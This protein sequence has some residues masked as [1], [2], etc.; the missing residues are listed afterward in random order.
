[1]LVL[2]MV[3]AVLAVARLAALIADDE[4]TVSLRRRVVERFG[5]NS[6]PTKLVHCAPWCMSMWFAIFTMPIAVIWPNRWV[7]A[8]LSIPAGSMVAA[9]ILTFVDRKENP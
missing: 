7:L 6:L 4:I 3:T 9:M 1:V 8:V 5:A 2:V